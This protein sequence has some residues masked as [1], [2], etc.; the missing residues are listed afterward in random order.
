M[1]I[2]RANKLIIC[3]TEAERLLAWPEGTEIF[4]LDT[5]IKYIIQG[6][7]FYATIPYFGVTPPPNPTPTSIWY[8]IS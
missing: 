8:D 6:G 4:C 2:K 5:G 7:A 1:A 3:D